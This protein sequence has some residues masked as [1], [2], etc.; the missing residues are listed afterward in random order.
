MTNGK[1]LVDVIQQTEL[2]TFDYMRETAS[3]V[4]CGCGCVYVSVCPIIVT[5]LRC[6]TACVLRGHVIQAP[7]QRDAPNGH[8][9]WAARVRPEQRHVHG[10]RLC[11]YC[12]YAKVSRCCGGRDCAKGY[13]ERQGESRSP[14]PLTT[15][16]YIEYEWHNF[17]TG[18]GSTY[19]I[20][21]NTDNSKHSANCK[22]YPPA[23]ASIRPFQAK[24]SE[25]VPM[26]YCDGKVSNH[27]A[28]QW[29]GAG[30]LQGFWSF[31]CCD[32]TALYRW[33]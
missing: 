33:M 21:T 4:S 2:G 13:V 16:N 32:V 5:V 12:Y 23:C 28:T 14:F 15:S 17:I 31:T 29:R 27:T 9:D 1:E 20:Q 18:S 22:K 25:C 11:C 26:W 8:P 10:A 19:M 3:Q 7:D 30:E 24:K 6:F